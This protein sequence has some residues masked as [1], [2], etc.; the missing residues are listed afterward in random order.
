MSLLDR[1]SA[2]ER[3]DVR[4]RAQPEWTA[5]MLATLTDEYFS[6]EEWIFERK[7]DGERALAFRAGHAVRL[8]SRNRKDLGEVYPEIVDALGREQPGGDDFVVDG[9]IVAFDG[10]VTSFARLQGRM[11]KADPEA[12]RATGIAVFYYLFDVLHVD[13][14]DITRLPLRRRKS[15]LREVVDWHDPLRYTLHRDA[16]GE[17]YRE[18]ACRKGWEG[19]IAKR[20][21]APYRHSRSTDWL[22]FKCAKGQELVIGGYTDPKGSRHDFGALLLGYH[23]DGELVYAGKVG[24]GFDEETL[25]DLGSRLRS[26]QLQTPPF[27]RGRLP[28][29]HVHWVRPELV[30]Q[31]AFTEWTSDGRLRHPRFLGLRRDKDPA[32]VGREEP[33]SLPS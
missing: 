1:L 11:Q 5:P 15:L 3:Q 33:R 6:D 28:S 18:E 17:T 24:T 16:E 4:E 32:D 31:V 2:A 26:R 22:K 25:R 13:G 19:V 10:G 8:R 9:E 30:C 14:H 20:A 27:D 23:D 7:L 12:A 29:A 21:T